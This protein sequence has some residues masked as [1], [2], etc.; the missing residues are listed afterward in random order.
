M[1]FIY[2]FYFFYCFW[3][4]DE[5]LL[6]FSF[7]LSSV[8]DL[9]GRNADYLVHEISQHLRQGHANTP[10]LHHSS[11]AVRAL[12]G[13]VSYGDEEVCLLVKDVLDELL[14]SLDLQQ[15]EAGLVWEGLEVVAQSCTRWV[16]QREGERGV[17]GTSERVADTR[18]SGDKDNIS[19]TLKNNEEKFCGKKEGSNTAMGEGHQGKDTQGK[20]GL[21][22]IGRYFMDYHKEKSRK[23]AEDVKG[24]S[25]GD[26]GEEPEVESYTTEPQL[27][28][29]ERVA[30]EILH[31]S[32]HYM[33]HPVAAVRL[34][35]LTAVQGCLRTLQ[36]HKV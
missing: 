33:S 11:H 25:G 27:S 28:C 2:L 24:E 14:L 20:E 6:F 5:V 30:V 3:Q 15:L 26:E 4:F 21:E 23:G 16:G 35:V 7:F 18:N 13:V 8:A 32:V 22:A 31:R 12:Q 34:K 36:S 10:S 29:C 17:A 9:I 19:E 1:Y